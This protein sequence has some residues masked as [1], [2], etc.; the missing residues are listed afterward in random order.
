MVSESGWRLSGKRGLM[1]TA[2][3]AAG[4]GQQ[5]T[6]QP[7]IDRSVGEAMTLAK[8]A[9]RGG[10]SIGGSGGGGGGGG[11]GS[12]GG[13]GRLATILCLSLTAVAKTSYRRRCHQSPL[14]STMIVITANDDE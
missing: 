8:A 5:T 11:G 1:W 9:G 2:D 4:K 10:G 14:Q 3:N 13:D 12:G 7:T 6:Q